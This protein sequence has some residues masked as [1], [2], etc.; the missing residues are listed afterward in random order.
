MDISRNYTIE[1]TGTPP[2]KQKFT[3]HGDTTV[4]T[5]LT[6][7]YPD[8]G[9]YKI[10]LEDGTLAEPTDWDNQSETWKVPT[11]E[12]CGEHRYVGVA[13]FLEFWIEPARLLETL[14]MLGHMSHK[15]LVF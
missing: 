7:N 6:I 15:N 11:G 4:G 1:Y 8:A 14:E 13:N 2:K 9:A 5:K 3:L 12:Y 10:Y